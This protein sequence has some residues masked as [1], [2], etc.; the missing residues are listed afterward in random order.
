GPPSK[1]SPP[2]VPA[3]GATAL[4]PCTSPRSTPTPH[5]T[6]LN[7]DAHLVSVSVGDPGVNDLCQFQTS[8][9]GGTRTPNLL[10]RSQMLSPI[11]LRAPVAEKQG[12]RD[13]EAAPNRPPSY[14]FVPGQRI[15]RGWWGCPTTRRGCSST[16]P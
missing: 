15:H 5:L 16:T 2:P 10:I 12:Y 13:A 3:D 4:R 9:L 6:I 8:A 7:R 14:P 11:E 1:A